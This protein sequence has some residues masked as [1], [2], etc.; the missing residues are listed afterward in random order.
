M[1]VTLITEILDYKKYRASMKKHVK[2]H[3]VQTTKKK[4]AAKELI[5]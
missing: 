2:N 5:E 1:F 3:S 4:F